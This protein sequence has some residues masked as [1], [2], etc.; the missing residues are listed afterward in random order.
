M[1]LQDRL[2]EYRRKQSPLGDV[3][4]RLNLA[5]GATGP[6]GPAGYTPRAGVDFYTEQEIRNLINRIQANVKDG[7]VGAIGPMG[8]RGND[9]LDGK[10]PDVEAII[11]QVVGR[12][13][14]PKDGISPNVDDI[15]T[16]VTE[17]VSK[18]KRKVSIKD[19]YDLNDL[20]AFLRIGGFRG[21][22]GA[23]GA[24]GATGA[25]C[26]TGAQGVTGPT[27]A[28]GIQGT[29]GTNGAQG[30]TG[31]T[32]P[33]GAQGTAGTNGAQGATG[34]TGGGVTSVAA[35]TLGTTG[36]DLSSTV[37]NGTTT[38]VITLQV[39]T[40]S[41]TNRGALSSTDWSTFNNKQPAGSYLTSVGTGVA[42]EI[43]YWSGTNTLGSLATA[44]YPSLTELS[45]VKGVTS[46]IQTQLNGKQA[47]LTNSAGLST[48]IGGDVA[49][50]DGGTGTST[51]SITGTGAL[52][53]T[54]GGTNQ[55]V[56]L[57]PS[58][59]GYT[60][61]NGNV[62]IGTT[63]PG[64]LGVTKEL[65]LEAKTATNQV[66]LNLSGYGTTNE[67]IG[68]FLQF[69]NNANRVAYIGSPRLAGAD[70]S[71]GLVFVTANAGS[72]GERMR[73][74]NTGNVGIGTAGPVN[75]LSVQ[76]TNASAAS[77]GSAQ[78]GAL[79]LMGVSPAALDMGLDSTGAVSYG[80]LQARNYS[81]YAAQYNLSLQPNGGN[82]GIGTTGPLS[83]L[84]VSGTSLTSFTD[85]TN[86]SIAVLEGDA[87]TVG[88]VVALDFR[89]SDAGYKSFARVAMRM[90]GDGSYLDFGTSNAFSTGITNTAM[91]INYLG[92]VGIGTTGPGELLSLGT[93]GT[94]AGVLSL[95]GLTSG[96]A[97]IVVPSVA[98]TPTLTLPTVTGTLATLA[99]TE[100]FTN[101][102]TNPRLVT[103]ASYTTDTGTSLDVS[104]C[105]QFEITAQ[106]GALLFN[107][108][109][110]T[111][112]GGNKLI[113]RIKD[114][115]TARA[116]TWNAVFRA[117]GTALPSTTVLSKTL[118]LGFIYNAT[119]TKWDLIASAQEA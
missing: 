118:Y 13:P 86:K 115:A 1:S 28:Q 62:G 110:G 80:W 9:G 107:A 7:Q 100:T 64:L 103:A 8:P 56:T 15:V 30:A 111:P 117:M 39:P 43:T 61:L 81:N 4:E 42:N 93:A 89:P 90:T 24:N 25:T 37:A 83:K 76:G 23:G 22:G 71:A 54:A 77:T 65:T 102:R 29:A 51:G 59:T 79:R 95:A 45:Y 63:A 32:G 17:E 50:V 31:T 78:N 82:V 112:V 5:K 53:Y 92:N 18:G 58:G 60:I 52:V 104:T 12:I 109:G 35:L 44:T 36:T 72:L 75:A 106:A 10:T 21:G 2:N 119:D 47:T 33:T 41:A 66:A 94:T 19:I 85:N 108:P 49:V 69:Y 101:K 87:Y 27:G 73:I 34:P 20:V 3:V 46:A 98:G 26:P 116:L 99:G 114:N 113:I 96:K 67:A 11:K 97:I 48:A 38:P 84:H 6:I 91:S 40:A 14:R 70:T 55:N 105:D 68:A 74:D 88:D 16:K 57:T